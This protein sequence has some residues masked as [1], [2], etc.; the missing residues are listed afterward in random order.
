VRIGAGFTVAF[1][2]TLRIPEDGRVYPLPPGLGVFPLYRARDYPDAIPTDWCEPAALFLPMYQREALW[3]AFESETGQPSALQVGAGR[4]NAI[5]GQ[6]WSEGLRGEPQNY[7]VCPPQ[8]WLDGFN[9]GDGTIRQFVA[10]PLG[11][12]YTVE[13]QISGAEA[14]GGIQFR[15]HL[16][17]PRRIPHRP[18]S[19]HAGLA[20]ESVMGA[21]GLAAGGM[22]RQKIYDDPFRLAVWEP[23]P[24]AEFTVHV[25]NSE[26]FLRIT[27]TEPPPSPVSARS[28]AESGLP[29]FDL[30]EERAGH[31]GPS[32]LL[33][34]ARSVR[35]RDKELGTAADGDDLPVPPDEL[36]VILLDTKGRPVRRRP[37]GPVKR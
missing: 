25:A 14:F 32:K 31:V 35:E 29:W 27:G 7:L 36:P 8:L 12:G 15:V 18:P 26:Q 3:I 30:H 2:R 17:R 21:M 37:P 10:M 22:I 16:P 24:C 34:R 5:T 6:P 4:V 11:L 28:Y 13:G 9:H 23:E 19:I 33:R 1:Q 20:M